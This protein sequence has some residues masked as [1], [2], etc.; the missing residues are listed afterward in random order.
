V[1]LNTIEMMEMTFTIIHCSSDY[2]CWLIKYD[3]ALVIQSS[4]ILNLHCTFYYIFSNMGTAL[5]PLPPVDNHVALSCSVL[6]HYFF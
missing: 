4:L 5:Y 3:L 1:I 2:F 6:L